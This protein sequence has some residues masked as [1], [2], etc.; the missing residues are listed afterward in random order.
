MRFHCARGSIAVYG[1]VLI[2]LKLLLP[3]PPPPWSLV[4][5]AAK[6]FHWVFAF[7]FWYCNNVLIKF[8]LNVTR[9]KCNI[10]FFEL[11]YKESY[12]FVFVVMCK[13]FLCHAP[14]D[15]TLM[16]MLN[17]KLKCP[18]NTIY[19]NNCIIFHAIINI[20]NISR[21]SS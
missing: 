12:I 3:L 10:I 14:C 8:K 2:S 1:T 16:L 5:F 13:E 19:V 20:K 9:I 7:Q 21:L 17:A 11:C 15:F 4:P 18:F 6:V